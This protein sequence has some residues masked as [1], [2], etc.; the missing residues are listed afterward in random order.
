M[1]KCPPPDLRC[2]RSFQDCKEE[3]KVIM[4]SSSNPITL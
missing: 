3:G 4:I 1:S 2:T